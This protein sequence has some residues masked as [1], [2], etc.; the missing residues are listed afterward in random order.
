ML[1]LI[2]KLNGLIRIKVEGFKKACDY[3]NITHIEPNYII[4]QNDPYFSGLIDTDD[5]IVYNYNCNRIECNLEFKYNLY[6]K[7]I[8]FDNVIPNCKPYILLRKHKGSNKIYNSIAFKFQTVNSMIFLYEY[9]MKNRLYSDFK[10]Y[11][12]SK[13]KEFILIR[14]Y[15]NESKDSIE[16]KIYS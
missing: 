7:N 10:F 4:E 1:F 15:K 14:D 11:R 16:F 8:N 13:I 2:N 12:I 5:T 9:F 3:L 6:S